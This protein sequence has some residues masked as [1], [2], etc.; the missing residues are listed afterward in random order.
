V[1]YRTRKASGFSWEGA[2]KKALNLAAAIVVALSPGLAT[3]PSGETV[4]LQ[5]E[6]KGCTP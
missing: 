1:L 6:L 2:I 3:V 4:K 5:A